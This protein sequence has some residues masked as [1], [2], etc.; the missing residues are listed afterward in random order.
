MIRP[1]QEGGEDGFAGVV[2][3]NNAPSTRFRSIWN[4]VD[5]K[6]RYIA[7]T[8]VEAIVEPDGIGNDIWR[9]SVALVGIHWPILSESAG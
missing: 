1:E 5:F 3:I 4:P 6:R 9:E 7:V 2:I 8:Q